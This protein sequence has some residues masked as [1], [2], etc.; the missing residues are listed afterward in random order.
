[1]RIDDNHA[2]CIDLEQLGQHMSD[3]ADAFAPG[4]ELDARLRN[5]AVPDGLVDR[6]RTWVLDATFD[7]ATRDDA[8]RDGERRAVNRPAN[9]AEGLHP[10]PS[11]SSLGNLW[12]SAPLS[13]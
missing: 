7:G 6:L 12:D 3:P 4:D 11:D 5:V 10:S 1:M 13:S 2:T 9:L 8:T